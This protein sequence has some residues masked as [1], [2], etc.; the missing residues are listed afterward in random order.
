MPRL[1]NLLAASLTLFLIAAR[2]LP[3]APPKLQAIPI[4]EGLAALSFSNV[5][6]SLSPGD[7]HWIA[8]QLYDVRRWVKRV[9]KYAD[10]TPSG[11][12]SLGSGSDIWL[13]NTQTGESRNLTRGQ[14]SNWAFAWSPN[15]KRLAFYSD[16]DGRAG[17]WLWDKTTDQIRK[18]SPAIPRPFIY[19]HDT[20]IWTPDSKRILVKVFPDHT[21]FEQL[22][23]NPTPKPQGINEVRPEIHQSTADPTRADS[24]IPLRGDALTTDELPDFKADLALIDVTD[25]A[26]TPVAKGYTP[27]GYWLSPDGNKLAFLDAKGV[28]K[29]G[30][31]FDLLLVSLPQ[32]KTAVLATNVVQGTLGDRLTWSPESDLICYLSTAKWF[33]ISPAGGA[34]REVTETAHPPFRAWDQLPLWSSD[35]RSLYFLT[36]NSLWRVA[37]SSGQAQEVA[38]LKEKRIQFI[39]TS[40]K[41]RL[42]TI[43]NNRSLVLGTRDD[44][45]KQCGFYTMDL[46]SG[47]VQRLLE[48][49]KEIRR[50]VWVTASAGSGALYYVAQDASHPP[51]I[52]EI[53]PSNG[54]TPRRVTRINPHLDQYEMGQGQLIEWVSNDGVR[55]RGALMLPAGY[56]KG[57]RYPLI[58]NVYGGSLLSDRINQFGFASNTNT[59]NQQLW[60]TRGYAV[61]LPDTPLRVATPMLDLAK[62][63][64]PGVDKVIEM[65]I[66]DPDR[67][68]VW[69]GSYGGYSTLALLVQTTRFKAAAIDSGFANL[70]SLYGW[71]PERSNEPSWQDWAELSQGR[72]GGTPWQYRERYIENSPVFYL[73]RV[74]TPLLII[75]GTQ[76]PSGK[77]FYSNEIFMNLRRLGKQATYVKYR[78]A[79]HTISGFTYHEQV[80][81][82]QRMLEWFDSHLKPLKNS[83]AKM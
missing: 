31:T 38:Q 65:G 14:G 81:A 55:I 62:T 44:H 8:Y 72:M 66:A 82:I 51:D 46:E 12:P 67:I 64:L 43:D 6:L 68:G 16:R 33:L 35:G 27:A 57:Q 17:I 15:G 4:S 49:D 56:Q 1:R 36:S 5:S 29:D 52:W 20:P 42:W 7:E 80:D 50:P 47:H 74:Q 11:V 37:A 73:D 54:A 70:M 18:L 71:M 63:V 58:V 77:D 79:S 60:A 24:P 45:T 83:R 75:Q 61:L 40:G 28:G 53:R 3:Q 30:P 21:T 22:V 59:T 13:T 76:D 39:A 26:L 32:K 9:G 41:G 69:G 48:V 23:N 25:G 19:G 78:G 34:P 10:L 2:A